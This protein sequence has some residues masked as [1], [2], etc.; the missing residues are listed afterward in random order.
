MLCRHPQSQGDLVRIADSRFKNKVLKTTTTT[1]DRSDFRWTNIGSE[2]PSEGYCDQPYVVETNDG[3]WLCVMTTGTGHE[4][5]PGQ[6]PITLR[7]H[8]HGETWG[9]KASLE[10]TGGPEASYA[11]LLKVPSGRIYAFYNYNTDRVPEVKTEKG[12]AVPSYKRVDSLGDYVFK[13][14]DDGGLSWSDKRYTIPVREFACDRENVYGGKIRFFWNVGRPCIRANGEVIIPLHKVGAMGIGFF[15]QSEG[16]F[17]ASSNI[18]TETDPEKIRFETRPDG[19]HGLKTPAGG[20]RIAEEQSLVELSDG[21]L[22][23]VYRSV[24]G[25]PVCAYSR[26][27]GRN[28]EAPQYKTYTPGGRRIKNPRAANFVWKCSNGRFLYWFHNHGGEFIRQLGGHS[29]M[30][31]GLSVNHFRTPYDDRNPVWIS[32]G[33]EIEGANGKL[34][35]WSQPE[36]L[37]YDDDPYIRISYPDLIEKDGQFWVTETQ[38]ATARIHAVDPDLID[39]LFGQSEKPSAMNPVGLLSKESRIAGAE[40]S[41]LM[42]TLP[43][44]TTR[45]FVRDDQCGKDLRAGCTLEFVFDGIPVEGTVLFD[46]RND[47][48]AGILVSAMESARIE[49][50]FSDARSVSSWSSDARC[51][52][53]GRLNHVSIIVDGGPKLILFVIN[54]VLCDGGD[55]RQFG[56]GRFN[57]DLREFN[58][59]DEAKVHASVSQVAIFKHALRV[60]EVV[61]RN[62]L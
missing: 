23:C 16:A 48:G 40:W 41:F 13:Y 31:N 8:D 10:P 2:I 4:G 58:G 26:D 14:S 42:P 36:I 38:K 35:E 12:V 39:G 51:L 15:A 17:I 3:V 59:A 43:L 55:E 45:D 56:W 44:L 47:E 62:H 61:R 6:H 50:R 28:W 21:S 20:G 24:D 54:G 33:R 25:W 19:D 57:R 34:I 7:S 32:A 60:S 9:E 1:P 22:Y 29:S 11:V 18:L 37:L 49:V 30:P 5:D 52:E 46:S 53:E 27:G